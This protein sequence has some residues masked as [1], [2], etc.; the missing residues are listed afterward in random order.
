MWPAV[1]VDES[2]I[3]AHGG[4][5]LIRHEQSVLVQFF[6]THDFARFGFHR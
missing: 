5:Q 3:G 1:V 6:G 4:L 2:N